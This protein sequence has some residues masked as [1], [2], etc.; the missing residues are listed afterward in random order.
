[1]DYN[2]ATCI[3]CNYQNEEKSNEVVH[4]KNEIES[5]AR[6]EEAMEIMR[7]LIYGDH[8]PEMHELIVFQKISAS[9]LRELRTCKKQLESLRK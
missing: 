5:A 3:Y 8:P 2:R 4:L 1:V 9:Q 7:Y 6:N